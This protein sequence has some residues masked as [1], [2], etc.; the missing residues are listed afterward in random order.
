MHEQ[1]RNAYD[2]PGLRLVQLYILLVKPRRPYSLTDLARVFGCSRQTALRMMDQITRVHNVEVESWTKR[3]AR[4]YRAAPQP[5]P[6]SIA[7]T[8]ET[9]RDLILCQ[10]IVSYILPEP[11]REELQDTIQKKPRPIPKRRRAAERRH[12]Q[13]DQ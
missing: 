3:N 13:G 8:A 4:Y 5:R 7:L 12:S 1:A 2:S 6:A 11:L 10:D 9:L